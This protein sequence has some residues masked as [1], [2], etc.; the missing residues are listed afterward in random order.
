MTAA[1]CK[2]PAASCGTP[3]GW[4]AG[5]RCVRCRLAHNNDTNRR[6]G[7]P[8]AERHTFLTMLRCGKSVEEAA[9]TAGVTVST[10]VQAA[11]RDGELRA[12]L[13][14]MPIGVQSAAQRAE[15]LAAL[16]RC[17]GNQRLA[18]AQAGLSRSTAHNWR[19]DD[20]AFDAAV[21]AILA[22]LGVASSRPRK[23]RAHLSQYDLER[24]RQMWQ[25]GVKGDE[26]AAELGVNRVTVH[27]WRKRLDLPARKQSD[28]MARSADQFRKLWADGATY[29]QIRAVLGISDPT[30]GEWRKRLGL[31]GR[32]PQRPQT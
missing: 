8:R 3:A 6:R 23:P 28:L 19:Q 7:L 2:A 27:H 21:G 10:L 9:E 29:A 31:P 4:R 13:D 14:G 24:L 11:R 25:D 22:W 32:A 30:I 26:I 5:G 20:P 18:E 1:S 17:G 15:F 12:A 16:V